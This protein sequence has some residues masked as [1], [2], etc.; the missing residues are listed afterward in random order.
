MKQHRDRTSVALH[1]YVFRRVGM[2]VCERVYPAVEALAVGAGSSQVDVRVLADLVQRL[3][4][5]GHTLQ[6]HHG[7]VATLDK[8]LPHTHRYKHDH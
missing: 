2:Y 7:N 4:L 6:V 1:V 3:G 5:T 8:H